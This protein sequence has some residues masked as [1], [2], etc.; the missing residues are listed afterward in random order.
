MKKM[1]DTEK[2]LTSNAVVFALLLLMYRMGV[3]DIIEAH[4]WFYLAAFLPFRNH[5]AR[6]FSTSQTFNKCL[7]SKD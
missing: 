1:R 7:P 4:D 5:I 3:Q 6:I 2:K